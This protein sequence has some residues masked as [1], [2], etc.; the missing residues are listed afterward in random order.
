MCCYHTQINMPIPAFWLFIFNYSLN[1]LLKFTQSAP[2]DSCFCFKYFSEFLFT[3]LKI[4][5]FKWS[6]IHSHRQIEFT[7]AAAGKKLFEE[8][9]RNLNFIP[10]NVAFCALFVSVYVY[11]SPGDINLF[12]GANEKIYKLKLKRTTWEKYNWARSIYGNWFEL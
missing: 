5:F 8:E 6:S 4:Y 2:I 7:F 9:M 11:L 12:L 1:R 3:M 10:E